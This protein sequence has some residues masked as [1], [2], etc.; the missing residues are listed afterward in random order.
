MKFADADS[1]KMNVRLI[2]LISPATSETIIM[3]TSCQLTQEAL[4]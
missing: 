4:E 2:N 1:C 3:S